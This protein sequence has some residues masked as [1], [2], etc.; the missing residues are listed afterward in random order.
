MT[1]LTIPAVEATMVQ[2]AHEKALAEARAASKAFADHYFGGG[3]GG[4]CGFAWVNVRGA[5]RSNS[6]LGKAL[7][8]VGFSKSYTGNL[9]LWNG[10]NGWYFGQSVD[11]AEAGASAYALKFEEL[12]G[13]PVTAGSRLD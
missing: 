13:I 6:R 1:T 10:R 11:A 2:Y 8:T 3:D 9:Q 7:V 12:T 4:A 5:I